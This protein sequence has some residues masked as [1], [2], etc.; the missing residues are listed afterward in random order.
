MQQDQGRAPGSSDTSMKRGKEEEPHAAA[1]PRAL[2]T[3]CDGRP[4][5]VLTQRNWGSL[6]VCPLSTQW[7]ARAAHGQRCWVGADVSVNKA[8]GGLNGGC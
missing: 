4:S 6:A 7:L 3:L 5:Q 8:E 2:L 1:E